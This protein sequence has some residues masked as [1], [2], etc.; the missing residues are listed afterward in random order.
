[1][2]FGFPLLVLNLRNLVG[3][4]FVA[5]QVVTG[6]FATVKKLFN[7]GEWPVLN[8]VRGLVG[9]LDVAAAESSF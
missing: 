8:Q 6:F 1:M 5:D 3:E 4:C 7:F 2:T 9:F